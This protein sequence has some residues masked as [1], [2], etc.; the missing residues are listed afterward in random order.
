[1]KKQFVQ[2][3]TMFVFVFIV[4]ISASFTG[5]DNSQN[6]TQ[7]ELTNLDINQKQLTKQSAIN[8]ENNLSAFAKSLAVN[9]KTKRY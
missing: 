1:M 9:L 6:P 3:L 2:S 7:P 8:I 5:C 4:T